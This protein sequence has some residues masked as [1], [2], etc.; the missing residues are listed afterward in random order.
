M[1]AYY[2]REVRASLLSKDYHVEGIVATVEASIWSVST[3]RGT[4]LS[5]RRLFDV[6]RAAV[7]S[8]RPVTAV[9]LVSDLV[10]S[11]A[12]RICLGE[13]LADQLSRAH[14]CII[15]RTIQAWHGWLV[16]GTGDGVLAT[17]D[18]ASNAISAATTLQEELRLYSASADAVGP[19]RARIGIAAGDLT[20]T[21]IGGMLD[22]S[23]LAA[24]EATR[25]QAIAGSAEIV[26]SETVQR[27]AC[28]RGNVIYE[29]LEPSY[30][31]GFPSPVTARRIR[32]STRSSDG[33]R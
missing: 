4:E 9:V 12:Q 31:D 32:G 14:E 17:F 33:D 21:Q 25:L 27:L 7:M 11:T 23:G 24:V 18:S 8:G 6:Y 3:G 5:R 20:W 16:K 29:P 1:M 19:L 2:V 28:G 15:E 22:C 26:C 10:E 30:L 13:E